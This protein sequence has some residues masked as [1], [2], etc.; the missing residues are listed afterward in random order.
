M[1]FIPDPGNLF[2]DRGRFFPDPAM[3]SFDPSSSVR[4][5]LLFIPGSRMKLRCTGKSG[6]ESGM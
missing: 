4:D 5:P 2:R 3:S 1:I 6:G